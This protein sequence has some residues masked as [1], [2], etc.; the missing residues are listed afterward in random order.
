MDQILLLNGP[1]LNLLGQRNTKIYGQASLDEIVNKVEEYLKKQDYQLISF[2]SNHEGE[3]I[4]R[5]HEANNSCS[6]VIFN[7]GGYTH[8]SVALRDAVE[9][10]N[11]PVIEVHLSNVHNREPF[12]SHSFIAP[13]AAGQI[14]GLGPLGYLTAAYALMQILDGKGEF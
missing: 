10:L 8:T 12:R 13:V 1:N 9:V 2:Q 5:L 4:D 7:P 3:L 6:G 11:I 14:L